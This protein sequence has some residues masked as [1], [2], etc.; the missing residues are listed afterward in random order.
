MPAGELFP[1]E[2]ERFVLTVGQ[3]TDVIK[4]LLEDTF[5]AVWVA[6][7]ISNFSR[8][9]SGHCY[10]T[11]KDQRAQ[12]PAVI[13]RSTAARL[14]FELHD[15]LEVVC[16][17][18]INV[19]PPHGKYQ[20]V[21][22]R[23]EPKGLGAL[24]LAFRQLYH[25]LAGEGLFRS[26]RKR[27][28]PRF[29]RRVALVTSPSG[30]AIRDFLQVLARRWPLADVLVL[31][32]A[33]QGEEAAGQIAAAIAQANRLQCPIDCIVV[34]RGGGSLEDLWAFNEEV[35]V[36]AIAASR[37]CVVSAVG[38]EIDVTLS[39][40]A[41][42]ARAP[43]PSSAAERI[44]PAADEVLAQLQHFQER[45]A[46]LIRLQL[47]AARRRIDLLAARP[48]FRRPL[49]PVYAWM[50]RIDELSVRADRAVRV[51]LERQQ[52]RLSTLAAQLE[53]LS[54]LGILA[55]GYSLTYKAATGSILREAGQVAP[56]DLLRTRLF[57]GQLTSRVEQVDV[58]ENASG[59]TSSRDRR[60]PSE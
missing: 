48:M 49:E 52:R 53:A 30:A 60:G 10:L 26:E 14:R 50:Q 18:R 8:P 39:D 44:S 36:R 59:G 45:L 46:A 34:T 31:P 11:L 2:S 13:W 19:Y 47:E 56:G 33:V 29:V 38:H 15:G 43:T 24:E 16:F 35:V 51:L 54:P 5:P 7:E 40:L 1:T 9:R 25:K 41:A 3:L 55:R 28:L 4:H 58:D 57:R 42:D 6:G 32:V 37:I 20:L 21:I 23:I 27:P 12:L 22:E 17:G